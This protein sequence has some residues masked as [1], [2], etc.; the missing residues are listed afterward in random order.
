MGLHNLSGA[1]EFI[2]TKDFQVMQ[3]AEHFMATDIEWDPTGR[4][5]ASCVS[6][7]GHKVDNAYWIWSFQG[8]CMKRHSVD[9]F[10]QLLWR[11]RPPSL[12]QSSDMKQMAEFAE[13]RKTNTEKWNSEKEERVK[14]RGIDTES[15]NANERDFEEEIVEFLIKKETIEVD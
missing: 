5:V 1:L 9:K 4:Y 13:Y 12:I 15:Q 10:C 3:T 6:W 14:L 7:W 11:P 2:D 8:K